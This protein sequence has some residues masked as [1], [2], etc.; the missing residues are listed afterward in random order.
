MKQH[1]KHALTLIILPVLAFYLGWSLAPQGVKAPEVPQISTERPKLDAFWQVWDLLEQKYVDASVLADEQNAVYGATKGLVR[2][3]GDPFSLFMTP[4]ENKDFMDD[5]GGNMEGIGAELTMKNEMPTVV[6]PVKGSPA[7]KAGIMPQ[8]IIMK[9]NGEETHGF[10]LSEVVQKIR[11]PKD[12]KVQLTIVRSSSS[13]PI[14]LILTREQ[15]HI[16]SVEG[17]L[18]NDTAIL[19]INQFG[20]DTVS[21]FTK[22]VKELLTKHPKGIILDLRFNGGGYLDGAVEIASIFLPQG[23]TVVT[24]KERD[25]SKNETLMTKSI[26][27]MPDVPMIVLINEGSASASEILAGA[28]QDHKRATLLG[29]KSFGKGTVQEVI[30]LSDGS[31]LR[32]TIAKWF[33]PNGRNVTEEKISPDTIVER[34]EDDFKQQKDPQMAKA[35][36]EL[37]KTISGSER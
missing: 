3:L 21:E 26:P 6:S 24:V 30:P 13:E 12:T 20:D 23:S 32:V 7:A 29:T 11:G 34:T 36:E 19:T 8:D 25:Q 22:N 9:V 31:A 5:L 35:L 15:I 10:T 2:S 16:P 37:K 1:V 33:T 28:L 27:L 18:K 14:E 4:K 17:E